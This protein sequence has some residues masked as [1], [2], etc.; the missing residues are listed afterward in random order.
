M[1][2]TCETRQCTEITIVDDVALEK[3]EIFSLTSP[4]L[5]DRITFKPAIGEIRIN[6]NDGMVCR[7]FKL[8]C[9]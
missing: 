2:D 1:F 8:N 7:Y 9:M 4:G 3:E 6:A 5:D